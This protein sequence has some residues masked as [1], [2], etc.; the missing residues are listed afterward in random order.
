MLNEL[1]NEPFRVLYYLGKLLQ[2]IY[3]IQIAY[4]ERKKIKK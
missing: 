2:S 3:G 1:G 4:N